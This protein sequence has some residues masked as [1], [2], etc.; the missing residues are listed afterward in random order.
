MPPTRT[1]PYDGNKIRE[2]RTRKGLSIDELAE[3]IGRHPESIRNLE[4]G[5]K[6][7]SEVMLTWIA[8]AV[9]ATLDDL[10]P[11][12]DTDSD[13]ESTHARKSA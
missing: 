10:A 7:A 5:N 11:D 9:D 13:S 3:A 12:D 2:L 6:N 8:K 1:V 4:R